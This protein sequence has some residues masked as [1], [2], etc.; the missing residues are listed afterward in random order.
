MPNKRPYTWTLCARPSERS[1]GGVEQL[2]RVHP[3]KF[4]V[5]AHGAGR[6]AFLHRP[7]AGY[8][9]YLPI[10]PRPLETTHCPEISD[11]IQGIKTQHVVVK[12]QG[13]PG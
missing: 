8:P 9:V 13:G 1:G 7:Q 4:P 10:H 6:S 5:W 11:C 2:S 3:F 12:T